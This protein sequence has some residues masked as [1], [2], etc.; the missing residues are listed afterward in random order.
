M[1]VL[2]R[3]VSPMPENFKLCLKALKKASLENII[4]DQTTDMRH[5]LSYIRCN[6]VHFIKYSAILDQ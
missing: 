6:I 3:K 5:D 2:F 4:F 1:E